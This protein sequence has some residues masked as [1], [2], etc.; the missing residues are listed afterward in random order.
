MGAST[1]DAQMLSR[2]AGLYKAIQSAGTA[3]AFGV[4]AAETPVSSR[5]G[6]M[7][8]VDASPVLE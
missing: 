3:V 7:L 5:N 4:D 8:D 6:S 2:Y 1:N